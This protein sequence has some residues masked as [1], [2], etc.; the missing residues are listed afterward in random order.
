MRDGFKVIDADRHVLEPSDLFE[1][2][3]P[4]K[5]RSRV[6]IRGP[7]QSYRLVDGEKISGDD[8]LVV[9]TDYPHSDCIGEFPDR[10]VGDLTNN[11][12]ISQD[13]RRKILWDNP[14]RLYSLE[15]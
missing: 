3:L 15:V 5:F 11:D 8:Y 13:G 6:E 4:E 7:N 2:Y 9:A 12:H 14:K 1:K 10:T